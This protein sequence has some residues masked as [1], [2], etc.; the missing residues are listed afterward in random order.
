MRDE[1]IDLLRFLGLAMIILAHVQPPTVLFQ[2]RNFDVPLMVLISGI[3][4]ALSYKREAYASYLWKRVKRLLFPT[5]IF[6]SLYFLGLDA[7]HRAGIG[8][9]LPDKKIIET[10]Y[11]LLSGI[12]YVWIIRVFLSVALVAPALQAV[13]HSLSNGRFYTSLACC[14]VAYEAALFAFDVPRDT[15]G[16]SLFVDVI[17]GVVPYVILFAA[18]MRLPSLS[19]RT[20][21]AVAGGCGALFVGLAF[22][23]WRSEGH[24]VVTQGF[25]YPPSAYYLSY[26]LAVS[27]G[28]WV[29]A[30]P[31]L[32]VV[33]RARLLMPVMFMG[34]NSIWVY[35]W[36]I[37]LIAAVSLPF[38]LKYPVVLVGATCLAAIQ[39]A[40]VRKVL[41]PK[42]H[43]VAIK[44][45][46]TTVFTG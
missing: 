28:A 16:Q 29:A 37:P 32:A 30:S 19:Q 1:K 36:H 41:V 4:F 14:Y 38:Y 9:G 27:C 13:S 24:I 3:S 17:L 25:K 22:F 35:L 5:W 21:M 46:L 31:L 34:Q 12:G 39:I 2:L 20:V 18:G 8:G 15:V 6:L 23:Y 43:S 45:T 40:F 10:S 7:L 42:I 26:A 44:R 11:L 33:K